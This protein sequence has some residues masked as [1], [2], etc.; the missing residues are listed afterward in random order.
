MMTP[1]EKPP[2]VSA[3]LPQQVARQQ[4]FVQLFQQATVVPEALLQRYNLTGPRYTSY[5]TAPVWSEAFEQTALTK[6]LQTTQTNT[7]QPYSVYVHL[8]FCAERCLFCGCNVV[9]TKQKTHAE[10]YLEY[11]EKELVLTAQHL[12]VSRP[13]T[14]FHYGGGTPTYLTPEQ[15]RAI[16]LRFFEVFTL[17]PDAELAIEVDPRVTTLA[18]L[19][20]LAE[21]GFNRISLGVQDFNP[22]TQEAINRIQ[23]FEQTQALVEQARALGFK[24]VNIDLI[25]G[26][27]YQTPETFAKTIEQVLQLKPDRLALYNYAYIPWMA[28]WQKQMPEEALPSGESKY[29][30]FCQSTQQFL[31]AGYQYIGMDHFALPTDELSVAWQNE[32]LNRNFMGYTTRSGQAELVGFGI[33]AIS[34]WNGHYSQNLKKLPAYYEALDAGQLPTWRGYELSVDDLI[35]QTVIQSLMCQNRVVYA[36]IAVQLQES[37][38]F[39]PHQANSILQEFAFETYFAAALL[40]LQPLVEDG[41]VVLTADG[42]ELTPLGRVFSRNVA[43]VF[44]AHLAKPTEAASGQQQFSRTL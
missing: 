34:S 16:T 22:K 36:D 35:R 24:G 12:D 5:P 2:A 40:T 21:L 20:V 42:F 18:H 7:A 10:T 44:D 31:T 4:A 37:A 30:I 38:K 8:P 6:V 43:M 41:L 19:E 29:Q 25:Y 23:P 15:L 27:P 14:Q 3:S 17:A 9:I 39:R 32:T 11:L 28:P 1:S 13:V 26:L 33:S